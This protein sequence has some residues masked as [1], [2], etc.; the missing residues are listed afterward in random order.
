MLIL[1]KV[2]F[3]SYERDPEEAAVVEKLAKK[4]NVFCGD[5]GQIISAFSVFCD[6]KEMWIGSNKSLRRL[7]NRENYK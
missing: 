1:D 4:Q 7:N 6:G 5:C 3:C 2:G